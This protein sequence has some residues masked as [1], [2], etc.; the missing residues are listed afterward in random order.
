MTDLVSRAKRSEIMSR[1]R[2]AGNKD[3]ELRLIEVF[4]AYRITSWR[5]G[6]KLE[7]K[8]DFVFP[9]STGSGLRRA[10][11]TAVFVDGCFWHGCPKH[12]TWPKTR[13]AF[14]RKKIE[15]NKA[16]DR[17]VNRILRAKGWKVVR[18]WQHE[19]KKRDEPKLVRKLRKV[20]IT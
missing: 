12:A 20:L 1:I 2:G 19:L 10:K 7:G 11:P 3:T 4:R 18:V 6:S 16:R 8:P 9:R 14:W 13:A 5:R 15:G 17:R